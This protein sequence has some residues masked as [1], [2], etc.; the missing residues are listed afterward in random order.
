M[1]RIAKFPEEYSE[2][3]FYKD[4]IKMGTISTI[5][6]NLKKTPEEIYFVY[7]SR[8]EIEQLFDIYKNTLNADRT[9]M[10][11]HESLLGWMFINHLAIIAYYKIYQILKDKNLISKHSVEDII[12]NLLHIN[13]ININGVWKMQEV[14]KKT[15]KLFEKIN[16]NLP[17]TCIRES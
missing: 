11:S 15:I 3:N 5:D 16:Y 17:I 6:N 4:S 7:K 10:H 2:K 8:C 9:Y 13:A 14:A 12:N 1:D